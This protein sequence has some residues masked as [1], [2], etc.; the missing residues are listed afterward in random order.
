MHC[1]A[2]VLITPNYRC[3]PNALYRY[4]DFNFFHAR[5]LMPFAGK[6]WS[7]APVP[8]FLKGHCT[9]PFAI[10]RKLC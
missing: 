1:Y 5:H 2:D 8:E 10:A 7:W 3:K 9:G 6:S 4:T